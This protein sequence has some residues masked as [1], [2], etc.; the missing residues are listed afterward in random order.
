MADFAP[1]TVPAAFRTG[2]VLYIPRGGALPPYCVKCGAAASTP[3]RKKFYWHAPW[4]YVLLLSPIIYIIVSLIVRKQIELNIP[5]CDLH[6]RQRKRNITVGVILILGAI[7][8]GIL[9]GNVVPGDAGVGFGFLAGIVAF[10]VG[11]VFTSMANYIRP[12]LI[13]DYHGEFT[14]VCETFLS[15]VP[16]Q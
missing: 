7:P 11:L 10:I 2:N 15:S 12:R 6:H 14:G 3:W 8:L 16:S 9:I 13:D 5:L 1:A 4:L